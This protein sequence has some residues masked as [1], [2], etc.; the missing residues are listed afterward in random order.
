LKHQKK[1]GV[2]SV[3]PMINDSVSKTKACPY[4]RSRTQEEPTK[5]K[6]ANNSVKKLK[7][8]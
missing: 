8:K 6:S 7:K 5:M 2:Y 3:T 1:Y 4:V